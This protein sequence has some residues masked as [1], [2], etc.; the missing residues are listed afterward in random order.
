MLPVVVAHLHVEAVGGALGD[1]QA[2]PEDAQLFAAQEGRI[3]GH[4]PRRGGVVC[5][6]P[7]TSDSSNGMVR[8]RRRVDPGAIGDGDPRLL[9]ACRSTCSKPAPITQ[10]ISAMAGRRFPRHTGP[11]AAGQDRLICPPWALIA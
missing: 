9:A 7:R 5:G 10:M 11:A 2:P 6:M 4:S 8:H 3:F 1:L